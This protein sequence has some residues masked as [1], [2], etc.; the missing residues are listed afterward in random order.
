MNARYQVVF[1]HKD[2]EPLRIEVEDSVAKAAN[3]ILHDPNLLTFPCRIEDVDERSHVAVVYLGSTTGAAD[4]DV[5]GHI[6]TAI[7]CNFPILPVV[8][9]S[10]P[11][12]VANKLPAS[13]STLCAENWT[14]NR[15]KVTDQL[16]TML[17]LVEKERKIFIS[18]VQKES[19]GL[20]DQLYGVLNKAHFDVFVDRFAILPGQDIGQRIKRDLSDKAFVLLLESASINKSEWVE[21]EVMYAFTH[22]IEV[23]A[24]TM[25]GVN[26]SQLIPSV[27]ESLRIRPEPRHIANG[28][29]TDAGL[30]SVLT[31]IEQAHASALRRRREQTLGSI[32]E[33]LD[34]CGH[35]WRQV[36]DWS[37]VA[38]GTPWQARVLVITPRE[39]C[40]ADLQA[41]HYTQ[42]QT[43][44]ANVLC[45]DA[46]ATLVHRGV[47]M[48][49]D[50]RKLLEWIAKPRKL[51]METL[52]DVVGGGVAV[53]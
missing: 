20:A 6:E 27:D 11:G 32:T 52:D 41:L 26:Q 19:T 44:R 18:Y 12:N 34:R 9:N 36:G 25:P 7:R 13:I 4:S 15:S 3:D 47:A 28:R 35:K 2:M 40:P 10:D 49:A 33:W 37:V 21:Q 39:P 38:I 24:I 46:S 8:R 1:I 29:L 30:N 43:R 23:L 5:C 53:Q 16:L 17:A 50:Q 31:R 42:Q 48:A 14:S 51:G 45:H 22:S